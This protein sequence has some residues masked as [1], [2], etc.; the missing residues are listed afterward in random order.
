LS[1][2]RVTARAPAGPPIG[3]GLEIPSFLR[4]IPAGEAPA[5]V[6]FPKQAGAKSCA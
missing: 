2:T 5:P 3:D 6:S 1:P 4:R